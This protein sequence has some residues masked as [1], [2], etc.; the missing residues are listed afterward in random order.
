MTTVA[1]LR[2]AGALCGVIGERPPAA[3]APLP[4]T[5]AAAFG[6][7][8]SGVDVVLRVLWTDDS[9]EES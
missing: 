2:G 4:S 5:P 1:K 7:A 8:G 3:A 9:S 6:E